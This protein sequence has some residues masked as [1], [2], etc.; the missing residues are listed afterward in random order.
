MPGRSAK[1]TLVGQLLEADPDPFDL[2]DLDD[3]VVRKKAIVIGGKGGHT[4]SVMSATTPEPEWLSTNRA[5]W[6]EMAAVHPTTDLYDVQGV[7]DG[8]DDLRPWEPEEL[9]EVEGLDLVH[10]QCHIGTDSVGWARRGARVLGLDFSAIALRAA[11]ELSNVCDLEV[12]WIESDVY[13]A[14]EALGGR[15]FD[16]VYTGVGALGW[17]PDLTRWAGV[18]HALLRPGGVLYLYELHPM[19]VALV[20]DGRT[21]CQPAIGAD[22]LCWDEPDRTSYA[23]PGQPLAQTAGWER[24]HTLSEVVSAL[25]AADLE[26]ELFHEHDA[27]PAPTPWLRRGTDGLYRFPD[28]VFPFPLSYSLRA[29]RPV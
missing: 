2:V 10:L 7:V 6:E 23:A 24:L 21:V 29:R 4:S 14:P 15:A 20:E 27:T 28:G 8:R 16:V 9:G 18:V 25:L 13:D 26:I 11:A 3:A 5:L 19:W 22:Y 17:L 1:T 12:E